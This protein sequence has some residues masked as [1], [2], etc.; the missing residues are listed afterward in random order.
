[1]WTT[2]RSSVAFVLI[3]ALALTAT[4]ALADDPT[5]QAPPAPAESSTLDPL[6]E[7]FR[8]GI[9][10]YRAGAFAEAIVIW[11]AI[12][13]ELGAEKGYRLAFDL[14]RAFDK[15]DDDSTQAAEYYDVYVRETA[16]RREHGDPLEPLV[17]KQEEEAKTRLAELAA[18][19]GRIDVR[20]GGRPVPVRIDGGTT[21]LADFVAYVTP[22]KAHVVTWSPGTAEEKRVELRVGPGQVSIVS[23]P[24]VEPP[25]PLRYE[26]RPEHPFSTTVL[27]VAGGVTL[28]SVLVPVILHANANASY[29]DFNS[30]NNVVGAT[31]KDS[32]DA[33]R[34]LT[35][36]TAAKNDYESARSTAYASIAIPA[37][38][39]VATL[40]LAAYWLWRTKEVRVPITLQGASVTGLGASF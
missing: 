32:P 37:L 27:Y 11:S 24:P 36:A 25:S 28:L 8:A 12:Y 14:A 22:D 35:N 5:P 3:A 7:R 21:R 9:E 19:R 2:T 13:T 15:L 38:L 26:T 17:A 39:G 30:A 34:V 10:K 29:D 31:R 23:P 16:R 33:Q 1:M 20:A 6:R 40:G 18:T 4:P